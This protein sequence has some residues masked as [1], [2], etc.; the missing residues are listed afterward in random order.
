MIVTKETLRRDDTLV[1]GAS[2]THESLKIK[3]GIQLDYDWVTQ[4]GES[5]IISLTFTYTTVQKSGVCDIFECFWISHQ[6]C[7][8]LIKNTNQ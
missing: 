1:Q 7:I 2:F 6:G 3:Q 4:T 5:Y 8:Y